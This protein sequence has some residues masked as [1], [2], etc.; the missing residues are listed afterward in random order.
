MKDENYLLDIY[1]V[2][3]DYKKIWKNNFY[4]KEFDLEFF[5]SSYNMPIRFKFDVKYKE[6]DF[7]FLFRVFSHEYHNKKSL[8]DLIIKRI[9]NELEKLRILLKERNF[10]KKYGDEY[11]NIIQKKWLNRKLNRNLKPKQRTK[12]N[13]ICL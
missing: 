3:E 11:K 9:I 2:I 8:E 10:I 12:I 6:N 1:S 13:K 4:L 5:I 7:K